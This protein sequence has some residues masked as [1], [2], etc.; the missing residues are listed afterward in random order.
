MMLGVTE[1][2][3][4]LYRSHPDTYN[5][6]GHVLF[7]LGRTLSHSLKMFLHLNNKKKQKT[8]PATTKANLV[9]VF[10][11]ASTELVLPQL[12]TF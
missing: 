5:L 11:I 1:E 10:N 6:I 8:T 7:S 3:F 12:K 9:L 4:V 2:L